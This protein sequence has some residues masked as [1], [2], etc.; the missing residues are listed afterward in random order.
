MTTFCAFPSP[1]FPTFLAY[2]INQGRVR[3]LFNKALVERLCG[4]GIAEPSRTRAA[5]RRA[6]SCKGPAVSA[7]CLYHRCACARS[8]CFSPLA[9]AA[10]TQSAPHRVRRSSQRGTAHRRA[11]R[12]LAGVVTRALSPNIAVPVVV[13]P[14]PAAS[15]LRAQMTRPPRR[16]ILA[17]EREA[18]LERA[19]SLLLLV[20]TV[21]KDPPNRQHEQCHP[22]T[23]SSTARR[24][25]LTEATASS[26][27]DTASTRARI[28]R[29]GIDTFFSLNGDTGRKRIPGLGTPTGRSPLRE[30]S[31]R[32]PCAQRKTPEASHLVLEVFGRH[33]LEDL[34]PFVARTLERFCLP[35]APPSAGARSRPLTP[36]F[37]T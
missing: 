7:A 14:R 27:H 20:S 32:V 34:G 22:P 2:E 6:V 25:C 24:C 23:P 1:L 11:A 16:L 36:F 26:V 37:A 29:G 21:S 15:V 19:A 8:C 3:M 30:T 18:L 31:P 4:L 10:A 28:P 35:A 13:P 12:L 33:F 9:Q 5:A 17:Q